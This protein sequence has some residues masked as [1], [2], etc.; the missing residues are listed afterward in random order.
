M[1][2]DTLAP[3]ALPDLPDAIAER[4]VALYRQRFEQWL[5]LPAVAPDDPAYDPRERHLGLFRRHWRG[6]SWINAAWLVSLGLRRLGLEREAA[7]LARRA[8]ATVAG[9]G[10]REYYDPSTGRGMGAQGFG[11]SSLVLEIAEPSA[12]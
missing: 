9:E 4:L 7:Q 8:V 2:W 1:T 10:L 12:L 5:P 3:L 11:W 6:P